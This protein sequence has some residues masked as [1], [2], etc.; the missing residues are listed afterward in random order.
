MGKMK[1]LLAAHRSGQVLTSQA[2]GSKIEFLLLILDVF[3]DLHSWVP[4]Q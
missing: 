3:N 1:T 2:R 4:L